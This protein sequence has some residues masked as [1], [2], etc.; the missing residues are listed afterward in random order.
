MV[1]I[2]QLQRLDGGSERIDMGEAL[3]SSASGVCPTQNPLTES[4]MFEME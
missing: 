1:H 2:L 3:M 4:P